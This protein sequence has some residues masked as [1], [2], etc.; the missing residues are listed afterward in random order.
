MGDV[1]VH[2]A[3]S[4]CVLDFSFGLAVVTLIFE[5]LSGK[6]LGNCEI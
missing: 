5:I 6:N 2:C 4:W 3:V 1:G